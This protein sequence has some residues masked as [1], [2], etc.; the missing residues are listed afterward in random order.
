M[1]KAVAYERVSYL[2]KKEDDQP[3]SYSFETQRQALMEYAA[4]HD[5]EI[6]KT[7]VEKK[8]AFSPGRGEFERMLDFFRA[9]SG[10]TTLLVYKIDRSSRNL[11]DYGTL[12]D[13]LGVE[14]IS[15]TEDLPNNSAGRLIG[16]SLAAFSRFYSAQLA[17]RTSAAMLTKARS[18]VYPTYAPIG[19]VNKDRN[20][21]IDPV[22]GPLIREL[23]IQYA[24]TDSSLHD[25]AEWAKARGL[26]SRYGNDMKKGTIHNILQN[27]VY[28]GRFKWLGDV[29]EGSHESLIS[30]E[31]FQAVQTKMHGRGAPR[32][33]RR[34]FPYRGLVFCGYCGCQLTAEFKKGKYIYYRCTESRGK[35]E[36]G[37]Y[38]Q[39]QLSER[40]LTVLENIRMTKENAKELMELVL[41]DSEE[42]RRGRIAKRIQLKAEEQGI[43]ERMD[44]MYEDRL[45]SVITEEQWLRRNHV[46]ETRLHTVRQEL[47]R[48]SSDGS[49]N[50]E[51]IETTLELA[52]RLPDLYLRKSHDER[53]RALKIVSWNCTITADNLEPVYKEPFAAIAKWRRSPAWLPG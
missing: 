28:V 41:R 44:A 40:L 20:I 4:G 18:G 31:L 1:K 32:V 42:H 46:Q 26:R 39:E 3:D 13:K 29:Y 21:S 51:A 33:V 38:T 36:Q 43:I 53:A 7:F 5:L 9:N 8:S 10:V 16:D 22:L 27:V 6:I 15:V 52:Q 30:E 47:G 49:F 19:Y 24:R 2:R 50:Q 37:R 14:I 48:T 12:V 17:E 23:F 45:D 25:L 11:F 35:C 34:E